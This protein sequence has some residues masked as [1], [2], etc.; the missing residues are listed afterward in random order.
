MDK[1]TEAECRRWFLTPIEISESTNQLAQTL[2][3]KTSTGFT[4]LEVTTRN[5]Q[6]DMPY[7]F[8]SLIPYQPY[9]QEN[10][11][12][13]IICKKTKLFQKVLTH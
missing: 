13:M 4:P 11:L 6:T 2:Q 5:S 8:F 3:I 9:Q 12:H 10:I 1:R 7:Q